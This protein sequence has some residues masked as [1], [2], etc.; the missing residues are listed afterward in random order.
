MR[1]DDDSKV[2]SFTAATYPL[3]F[4]LLRTDKKTSVRLQ[5]GDIII[6]SSGG[7]TPCMYLYNE[8]DT[9][10]VYAP[11]FSTVLRPQNIV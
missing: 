5:A 9:V 8:D 11:S 1:D 4:N 6:G 7:A 10:A 3:N 2:F